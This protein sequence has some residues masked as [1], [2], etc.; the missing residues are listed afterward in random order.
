[1]IRIQ[2]DRI[3]FIAA[4]TA[5]VLAAMMFLGSIWA[6]FWP[7][8]FDRRV[9]WVQ[10]KMADLLP[11]PARPEFVPTPLALLDLSTPTPELTPL[12]EA[13]SATVPSPSR[14]PATA[15]P[16]RAPTRLSAASNLPPRVALTNFRQDYQ[17]FNNCG[18]ATLA[19][20]LS[21]FGRSETQYDLAP[22]LKGTPDDRNVN[23]EEIAAL[24]QPYGLHAVV[25][26]NGDENEMKSFL[27]QGVPVM[28]ENW[29]VPRLKDASG[30]YRL[31]TGY[32]DTGTASTRGVGLSVEFGGNDPGTEMGYF[33]AQDSY[34]GP[35]VKLPYRSWDKDWAVF[36]RTYL[37]IYTDAQAAI[38]KAVIGDNADDATMYARARDVAQREIAANGNDAYAWFNLGSSLV[39]LGKYADAGQAF[40]Y[41][42]Q[43]KLPFRMLWYQ[44]GPY[45]AYNRSG[46]YQEVIS[47]AN[48]T[49][50]T[51][52]GLEES[53]YYRGQAQLALGQKDAARASFQLALKANPRFT[54]AQQALDSMAG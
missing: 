7:H 28:I 20:L 23:P 15:V 9:E 19:I 31:L 5:F 44:F 39:G 3:R 17:R 49:L 29:F 52:S 41:A 11:Q 45:E 25:R 46:R 47:L 16:T 24:V 42:R 2:P 1:M 8:E 21:H 38:V 50:A 34:T 54:P 12:P 35:N 27:A 10:L 48:A 37:V 51:F 32:D 33:I 36:N 40:D 18:P 6:T 13:T 53:L 26:V 43:L 30:H 4:L 22:L 14:P